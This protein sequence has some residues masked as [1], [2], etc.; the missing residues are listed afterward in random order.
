MAKQQNS[1][2]FKVRIISS[3]IL[4]VIAIGVWSLVIMGPKSD[5]TPSAAENSR[6]LIGGEFE[7]INHNN[8]VVTDKDFLGKY[9]I[10]Y[11]GYTYCPDVCPMDLQIMADALRYLDTDDLQMLNPVFV[12]IDPERDT[13]DVMAEYISF[14]HD[15]LIGLTGS[16]EQVDTIKKAYR[17]YAAKADDSEDY[18]VDHTAYTYLMDKEGK[19]LQHF[20]HGEDPEDMAAKMAALIQ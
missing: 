13:P 16:P 8:E 17:V 7:L 9:M 12:S 2:K 1:N 5:E 18:L 10:V 6:A 4:A 14:F 19:L 15:D 3:I 11:F 20:N